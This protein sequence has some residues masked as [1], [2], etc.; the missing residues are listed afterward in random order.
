[1]GIWDRHCGTQVHYGVEGWFQIGD[2]GEVQMNVTYRRRTFQID[3][4][5]WPRVKLHLWYPT[6][7]GMRTKIKGVTVLLHRYILDAKPWEVVKFVSEDK[8]D[9][10][11]SNLKKL[12][13]PDA[14]RLK[15]SKYQ[16]VSKTRQGKFSARM[17]GKYLG[18]FTREEDA[19]RAY[20]KEYEKTH[21]HSVN[22]LP[23]GVPVSENT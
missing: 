23:V 2:G 19:A 1:M 3:E 4:S 9:Y 16:G 15:G 21:G 14:Y 22:F 17:G 10:R 6:R 7:D 8:W 5:D 12:N 18:S 11:H 13:R 20:D